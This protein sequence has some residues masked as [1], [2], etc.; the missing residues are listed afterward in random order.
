MRILKTFMICIKIYSIWLI[1][2]QRY[3]VFKHYWKETYNVEILKF[4]ILT[5]LID[6]Y[7]P[8]HKNILHLQSKEDCTIQQNYETKFSKVLQLMLQEQ[9]RIKLERS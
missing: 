4:T 7:K 6:V 2:G 5:I 8:K 1:N 3:F 9:E